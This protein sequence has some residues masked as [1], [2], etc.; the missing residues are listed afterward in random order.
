MVAPEQ[1]KSPLL[2]LGAEKDALI[3]PSAAERSAAFYQADYTLVKGA[4]H[5][6]MLEQSYRESAEMVH[7]WFTGQGMK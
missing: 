2:W 5:D 4:G 1:V 6:L 7:D 3:A